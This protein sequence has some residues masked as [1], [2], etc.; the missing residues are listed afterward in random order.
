MKHIIGITLAVLVMTKVYELDFVQEQ[1]DPVGLHQ[2]RLFGINQLIRFDQDTIKTIR[3]EISQ[4]RN[5]TT[6]AIA[7]D[8]SLGQN[9]SDNLQYLDKELVYWKGQLQRDTDERSH[10]LRISH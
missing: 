9:H 6:L 1:V 10:L 7:H 5:T 2:K 4:A 3:Y 8:A